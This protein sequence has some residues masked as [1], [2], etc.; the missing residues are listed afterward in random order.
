MKKILHPIYIQ[1]ASNWVFERWTL[2]SFGFAIAL[3]LL[4]PSS[5]MKAQ[6]IHFSQFPASPMNLNPAQTGLFNGAYRFV[7]NYRSQWITPVPYTTLSGSADMETLKFA[8]INGKL[9]L[10]VL[11]NYDRA[12][13]SKLSLSQIGVS[14]AYAQALDKN[15]I[16][17]VGFQ[18]SV[19]QR[20][21]KTDN[22]TFDRQFIDGVFDGNNPTNETFA[23]TSFGF[24]DMAAG[25][26]YRLQMSDRT[27]FD[28]GGAMFHIN[29]P[30]QSFF[31]NAEIKLPRKIT[32]SISGSAQLAE[33]F[34]ILPAF[35]FQRQGEYQEMVFGTSLKMHLE[36]KRTKELGVLVGI[37]SRWDD[38]IIASAGVH[39][40]EW[41]VGLSYDIN[42]S[43][44]NV[45]TNGNGGPE[46]SVIYIIKKVE[47]PKW[48]KVC[49]IF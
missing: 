8:S 46:L 33:N 32:G 34:D 30:Q 17:S 42:I 29:R 10:G 48:Q 31:E 1:P 11:F 21:Y 25:L 4:F 15:N 14:L 13:D 45:A 28:I 40:K 49:P 20:A 41:K 3:L 27:F 16:L 2:R 6:D 19:G 47:D 7:A 5:E 38:A 43:E 37:W 24:V 26:N 12:G 39:Y 35:I 44:F 9:G 36:Q 18:S 22:L 23:N